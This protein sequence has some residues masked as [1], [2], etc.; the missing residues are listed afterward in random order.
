MRPQN[1]SGKGMAIIFINVTGQQKYVLSFT[2]VKKENQ[3][4][5]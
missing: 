1:Q 3:S 5:F 4:L 2:A